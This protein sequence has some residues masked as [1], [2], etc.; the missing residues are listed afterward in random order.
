MI[1]DPAGSK[2]LAVHE[3]EVSKRSSS[4]RAGDGGYHH[5]I[6][7]RLHVYNYMPG[8]MNFLLAVPC[9]CG[10][11]LALAEMPTSTLGHQ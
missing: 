8:Y 11:G 3:H 2:V 10:L 6:V 9:Y 4:A 5:L 1:H 7:F